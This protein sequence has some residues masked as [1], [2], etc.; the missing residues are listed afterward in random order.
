MTFEIHDAFKVGDKVKTSKYSSIGT[1]ICIFERDTDFPYRVKDTDGKITLHNKK[2]S[3]LYEKAPQTQAFKLYDKV[4]IIDPQDPYFGKK[5]IVG[6]VSIREGEETAYRIQ[7][8]EKTHFWHAYESQIKLVSDE[9]EE[10]STFDERQLNNQIFRLTQERDAA[11]NEALELKEEIEK[12]HKESQDFDIL[13]TY[14]G[15]DG[16]NDCIIVAK[17]RFNE[18][19]DECIN[20]GGT[21]L[22]FYKIQRKLKVKERTIKT[23]EIDE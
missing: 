8:E 10:E 15:E 11:K 2:S 13:I 18:E 14:F 20:H 12:M 3:F 21:H 9:Q 19:V 6:Y 5:G 22:K 16:L 17:D 1:V 23:Y 4:E 7:N